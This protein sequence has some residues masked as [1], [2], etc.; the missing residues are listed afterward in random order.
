MLIL[1]VIGSVVMIGDLVWVV[2]YARR[3]STAAEGAVPSPPS[4]GAKMLL[5]ANVV[6][7]LVLGVHVVEEGSAAPGGRGPDPGK[8]GPVEDEPMRDPSAHLPLAG[9]DGFEGDGEAA[10]DRLMGFLFNLSE[11]LV[12]QQ[13]VPPMMQ[14]DIQRLSEQTRCTMGEPDVQEALRR[15]AEAYTVAGLPPEAPFALLG[16]PLPSPD[17]LLTT[18]G[19]M[20]GAGPEATQ[21]RCDK[22]AQLFL[23]MR[24]ELLAG[25]G[26]PPLSETQEQVLAAGSCA[27]ADPSVEVGLH[28]Y[29]SA[30][31]RAALALN[32]D[33]AAVT[34]GR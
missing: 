4:A 17:H 7:V 30:Y 33:L 2:L 21:A 32:A 18:E 19:A 9:M 29:R 5:A 24:E 12:R 6:F 31:E 14:P 8:A 23:T 25:G 3:E 26:A 11:A 27:A 20:D 10:C 13:R 15:F 28:L 1:A 34:A 16:Q 22:L